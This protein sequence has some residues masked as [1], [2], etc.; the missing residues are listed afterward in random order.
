MEA[1]TKSLRFSS[2]PSLFGDAKFFIRSFY[3]RLNGRGDSREDRIG[4][5]CLENVF[6]FF[7]GP[8]GQILTTRLQPEVAPPS[9]D[10]F[11]LRLQGLHV[12]PCVFMAD[13]ISERSYLVDDVHCQS[14]VYDWNSLN[15]MLNHSC[16][17]IIHDQLRPVESHP[18]V[19]HAQAVDDIGA[20]QCRQ[21]GS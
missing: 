11:W 5:V 14:L 13:E 2:S 4:F 3:N 20:C 10:Q 1:G 12:S 9:V 18:H 21:Q 19:E 8:F 6:G 7:P 17:L 16:K 15:H